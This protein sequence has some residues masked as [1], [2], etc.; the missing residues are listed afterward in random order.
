MIQKDHVGQLDPSAEAGQ[1]QDWT[2]AEILVSE[3]CNQINNLWLTRGIKKKPRKDVPK[4]NL[5]STN[6]PDQK[7]GRFILDRALN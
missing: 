7:F 1:N 6:Y 5:T 4:R 3:E 2:M